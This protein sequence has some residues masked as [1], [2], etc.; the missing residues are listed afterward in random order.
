[1]QGLKQFH[2]ITIRTANHLSPSNHHQIKANQ[3]KIILHRQLLYV[4]IFRLICINFQINIFLNRQTCLVLVYSKPA[5][6]IPWPVVV[7]AGAGQAL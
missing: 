4:I 3:M 5:L 2:P 7:I 1:M 6:R